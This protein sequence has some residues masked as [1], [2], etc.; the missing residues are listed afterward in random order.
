MLRH[1][2][3]FHADGAWWPRGPSGFSVNSDDPNAALYSI[4]DSLNPDMRVNGEFIFKLSYPGMCTAP[5]RD[6]N[7]AAACALVENKETMIWRQTSNPYRADPAEL[8]RTRDTVEGYQ[9]I[10][11]SPIDGYPVC[12]SDP[13][14]Q[15]CFGGISYDGGN[16]LFQGIPD[17]GLWFWP[18]GATSA[19]GGR[20]TTAGPRWAAGGTQGDFKTT[21]AELYVWVPQFDECSSNEYR[22]LAADG[23][24]ECT[25][26]TLCTQ[27]QDYQTVAPNNI[28]DRTCGAVSVCDSEG[29]FQLSPPTLLNDRECAGLRDCVPGLEY[30]SQE[31][32]ATSDRHCTPFTSCTT[33]YEYQAADATPTSDRVCLATTDCGPNAEIAN[34]ATPSSDRVCRDCTAGTQVFDTARAVCQPSSRCTGAQY[35][36]AVAMGASDTDCRDRTTCSG[37]QYEAIA[38]TATSDAVCTATATCDASIEAAGSVGANPVC[39]D[40]CQACPGAQ[41]LQAACDGRGG[42][43]QCATLDP[44]SFDQAPSVEA[45]GA[46]LVLS[47]ARNGKVAIRGPVEISGV[48]VAAWLLALQGEVATL[49]ASL[50]TKDQAAQQRISALEAQNAN[51]QNQLAQTAVR[52][53]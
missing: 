25:A 6:G 12:Q 32:T 26:M 34:S 51:L 19:W 47:P 10:D 42:A 16:S 31:K 21:W 14:N 35:V 49:R 7:T 40:S 28:T 46:D 41:A 37:S 29:Q 30:M 33:P 24:Y 18:V 4:V 3:P 13:T 36:F 15:A 52:L 39:V 44:P 8:S 27:G 23:H 38:G 11:T 43:R 22:M 50:I 5:G 2:T 20:Q 9:S 48:D 45:D 17:S 53:G 1:K